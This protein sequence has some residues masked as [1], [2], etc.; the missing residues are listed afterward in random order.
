MNCILLFYT[1]TMNKTEIKYRYSSG[2]KTPLM[3]NTTIVYGRLYMYIGTR[4]YILYTLTESFTYILTYG[5]VIV[6]FYRANCRCCTLAWVIAVDLHNRISLY[7]NDEVPDRRSVRGPIWAR[8]EKNNGFFKPFL[9]N[10]IFDTFKAFA[11][12]NIF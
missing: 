12:E 5:I 1:C 4:W 10:T 6:I 11:L 3:T 7:S 9:F 2:N 8:W